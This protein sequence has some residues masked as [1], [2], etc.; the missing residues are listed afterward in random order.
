MSVVQRH[1]ARALL[2]L[3]VVAAALATAV[4]PSRARVAPML[5]APR[6]GGD[7]QPYRGLGTWVDI[8]D[9]SYK[10][11]GAAVRSMAAKGVRTLYLET[12]NYRH[13]RPFVHRGKV[14]QFLDAATRYGLK[15]VAWYLP[16]FRRV[17]ADYRRSLAAIRLHTNRGNRFDSFALDIESPEVRDP[18]TRTHRLLRLSAKLRSAVG[19]DYP[20]GGIIPSP[21]GMQ[22]AGRYWPRFPYAQLTSY[23]D[24]ILPMSYSTWH[25]S[26]LQRTQRYTER[27]IVLIRRETGISTFPIHVIGGIANHASVNDTR[28]FARAVRERGVLGASF[29]TFPLTRGKQW[30]VLRHVPANP[31]ERPAL[32]TSLQSSSQ[33]LGNIPGGDRTHPK[34]IFFRTGGKRGAWILHF[35]AFDVQRNEVEILVNW[36]TL[37]RVAPGRRREWAGGRT[38]RIPDRYLRRRGANVIAFVARGDYPRW[39]RWGVRSVS[40]SKRRPSGAASPATTAAPPGAAATSPAP[41]GVPAAAPT[42]SSAASPAP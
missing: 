22:H 8:F 7:V 26:G 38:R 32:P 3:A 19:S 37:G 5:P 40:L 4:G 11:P 34:E 10:H 23:Y 28:G 1:P 12:S 14:A 30:R 21:Y 31:V 24:V 27:N 36:R 16:S 33:G 18:S 6:V 20:L 39:T 9:S 41:T 13:N 29:Y 35:D 17:R 15:T 42:M 2:A 25:V